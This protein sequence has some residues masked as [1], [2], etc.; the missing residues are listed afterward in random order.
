ME[1]FPKT[2]RARLA[3]VRPGPHPEAEQLNAFAENALAASERDTVLAHLATCVDCRDVVALAAAARPADAA[4]VKPAR[5]GLRWATLQ[6]AAAAAAVAI[7]T[8]AVLVVGPRQGQREPHLATSVAEPRSAPVASSSTT[9]ADAAIAQNS[10]AKPELKTKN[11]GDLKTKPLSKPINI[12]SG[13]VAGVG[14]GS[15]GGIGA[16]LSRVEPKTSL[17]ANDELAKSPEKKEQPASPAVAQAAPGSEYAYNAGRVDTFADGRRMPAANFPPSAPAQKP[18]EQASRAPAD[19]ERGRADLQEKTSNDVAKDSASSASVELSSRAAASKAKYSAQ[20]GKSNSGTAAS[21][22]MVAAKL[23]GTPILW[24]LVSE[25][26]QSSA[27]NGATW[28]QRVPAKG[29]Q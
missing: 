17:T 19:E 3:A 20:A 28:Q 14:T 10:P 29:V 16:G 2:A 25:H 6:W 1:Q 4:L 8:V 15:G 23:D 7:V 27:D 12:G 26:I 24:R 9:S 13:P 22:A 18:A 5:A 11:D 21:G